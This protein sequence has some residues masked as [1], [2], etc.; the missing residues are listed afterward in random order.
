MAGIAVHH[1]GLDMEDRRKI[2]QWYKD[3]RLKVLVCTSVSDRDTAS[4]PKGGTDNHSDSRCGGKFARSY[5]SHQRYPDV[6]W[7]SGW[8]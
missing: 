3:G 8:I 5:C 4:H 2:E 1:A 6:E 7:T